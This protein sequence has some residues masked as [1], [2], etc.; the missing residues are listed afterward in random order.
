MLSI[1]SVIH[2]VFE[3]FNKLIFFSDST[4]SWITLLWPSLSFIFNYTLFCSYYKYHQSSVI[5]FSFKLL[6]D[7][8][9]KQLMHYQFK[10]RCRMFLRIYGT[11]SFWSSYFPW[12]WHQLF[13]WDV[14][15]NFCYVMWKSYSFSSVLSVTCLYWEV[16]MQLFQ[17]GIKTEN[18]KKHIFSPETEGILSPII[19]IGQ[20][21]TPYWKLQALQ[22]HFCTWCSVDML[23][24]ADLPSQLVLRIQFSLVCAYSY[25]H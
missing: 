17:M 18:C 1:T 15:P 19:C 6:E 3:K 25:Q 8:I 9:P 4:F 21:C 12:N 23:F 22:F 14:S 20:L 5:F 16:K 24:W 2:V 11:A 13:S 7:D 10:R